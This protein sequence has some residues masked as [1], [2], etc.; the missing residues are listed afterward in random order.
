MPLELALAVLQHAAGFIHRLVSGAASGLDEGEEKRAD[1]GGEEGFGEVHHSSFARRGPGGRLRHAASPAAGRETFPMFPPPLVRL[2]IILALCARPLAAAELKGEGKS[3]DWR[4]DAPGV[5]HHIELSDLPKPYATR[6]T[7]NHPKIVE[8]PADAK[9]QVP[10]GFAVNLFA[11][12][13]QNPRHLTTAPNGDIFVSESEAGLIRVLRDTDG[14][15]QADQDH[16]FA[17]GLNKPFGVAFFPPGREPQY[18][19][20]ANTDSVVRFSYR[21]GDVKA[22]GEPQKITELAAGG[23]LEGGGHWT[24][25]IVF[26]LDGK[27]LYASVGSKT[28][29]DVEN[30]PDEN[31]RARIY[32]MDPDGRAKRPFA[33]GIRNAV[34]L[35]IHPKSGDLWASVN[36]RDELGDD[37]VPDYI[38]RVQEGGF[39]GWPWSYLG[40]NRDPRHPRESHTAEVAKAITPDVLL[41]S[42][43]ASLNMTFYTG[44]SFPREYRNS[45]FA[46]FHGSWNRE[47]R[48]GYKVIRIATKEALAG[49]EYEDFLTGFVLPNGDV[50]GRP[51]GLCVAKDGALLVSEDG[52]KTIWRISAAKP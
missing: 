2:L 29:A 24:R 21:T 11:S 7:N 1:N 3:G 31:E 9:L 51:V 19:Y 46:A 26:S 48:T 12:G 30:D 35:A 15:G 40:Q 4:A 25:D 33:T 41:Q 45:A 17:T 8:R 22:G 14:D 13:L 10:A 23:K 16:E 49:N 37:L 42:H 52:N 39:Y 43:S 50:W 47:I 32:V 34:G 44:N 5:R 36:E 38:T 18:L 20:V 28:N 6:S 27:R